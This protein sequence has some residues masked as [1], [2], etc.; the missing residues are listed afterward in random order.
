LAPLCCFLPI[1]PF[2]FIASLPCKIAPKEVIPPTLRTTV[3]CDKKSQEVSCDKKSEEDNKN[4]FTNKHIQQLQ[5]LALQQA[6]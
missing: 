3:A 2:G 4:M 5:A 6:V 1:F